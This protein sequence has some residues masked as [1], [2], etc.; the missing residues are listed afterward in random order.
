MKNLSQLVKSADTDS[1]RLFN[2]KSQACKAAGLDK[3]FEDN[4]QVL[5]RPVPCLGAMESRGG[6]GRRGGCPLILVV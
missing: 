5:S 6:V 1:P 2:T 4:F 3:Q